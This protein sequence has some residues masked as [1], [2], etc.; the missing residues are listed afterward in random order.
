M[1]TRQVGDGVAAGGLRVEDSV[2]AAVAM[3]TLLEA[4]R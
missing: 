3:R 4:G 1:A 2:A